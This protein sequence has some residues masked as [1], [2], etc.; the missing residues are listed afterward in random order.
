MPSGATEVPRP[1]APISLD[2]EQRPVETCSSCDP[3][4]MFTWPRPDVYICKH[5]PCENVYITVS[6]AP[7]K[8]LHHSDFQTP[9]FPYVN[10]HHEEN[11]ALSL[12]RHRQNTFFSCNDTSAWARS[13][14]SAE[15]QDALRSSPDALMHPRRAPTAERTRTA[16]GD[17]HSQAQRHALHIPK[18]TD[19]EQGN[20]RQGE[21]ATRP[22]RD[23]FVPVI[24][25]MSEGGLCGAGW[26]KEDRARA[27]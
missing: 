3:A 27:H 22:G 18:M 17:A 20:K 11:Q 21:R 4:T 24:A 16:S 25:M 10:I 6:Q 15:P 9:N 23:V 26:L 12:L 7:K 5:S 14:P 19:T 2:L 13:D 8:P 1:K